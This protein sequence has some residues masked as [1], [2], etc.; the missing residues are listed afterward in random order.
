[1]AV[2]GLVTVGFSKPY[3]VL[4]A[5]SCFRPM[6]SEALPH[7]CRVSFEPADPSLNLGLPLFAGMCGTFACSES[8]RQAPSLRRCPEAVATR[9]K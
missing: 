2:C 5:Q 9:Y 4:A 1:M 7:L 6:F 3:T 8:R